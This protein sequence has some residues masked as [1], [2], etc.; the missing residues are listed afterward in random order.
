MKPYNQ[1]KNY[2]RA[3]DLM[4]QLRDCKTRR[5]YRL[6]KGQFEKLTKNLSE[7]L[8]DSAL[9]EFKRVAPQPS[10]LKY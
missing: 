4:R 5:R 2:P 1:A 7:T 9:R 6:L 8:R 3:I 10:T